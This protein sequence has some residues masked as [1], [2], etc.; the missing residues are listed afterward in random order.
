MASLHKKKT[1][2]YWHCALTLLDG[3]QTFR[4]TGT[5]NKRKAWAICQGYDKAARR[6]RETQRA[7]E[8]SKRAL[9]EIDALATKAKS[10]APDLSKSLQPSALLVSDP[11]MYLADSSNRLPQRS[12]MVEQVVEVLRHD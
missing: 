4:S 7:A 2:P 9:A 8:R 6:A 1:S 11:S 12:S 10:R 3:R 5:R